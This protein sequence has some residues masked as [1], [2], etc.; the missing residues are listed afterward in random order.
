MAGPRR[1][2]ASSNGCI[3]CMPANTSNARSTGGAH[4]SSPHRRAG[5]E[6]RGGRQLRQW[7]VDA[8]KIALPVFWAPTASPGTSSCVQ[9]DYLHATKSNSASRSVPRRLEPVLSQVRQRGKLV[10]WDTAGGMEQLRFD[11]HLPL[12][13]AS[14]VAPRAPF[15]ARPARPARGD[16]SSMWSG[17][18]LGPTVV[19]PLRR[20]TP[21]RSHPVV[22]CAGRGGGGGGRW[23]AGA[24]IS[25]SD[26]LTLLRKCA[27]RRSDLTEGTCATS[28]VPS[29]RDL[30]L[31][32]LLAGK[33][34]A[35]R[36]PGRRPPVLDDAGRWPAAA[37]KRTGQ[38]GRSDLAWWQARS[39]SRP[40]DRRRGRHRVPPLP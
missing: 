34:L 33:L 17:A 23:R 8:S 12:P 2:C 40:S 39:C 16:R 13:G 37:P 27:D 6:L 35:G 5:L 19:L 36:R 3:Q 22:G 18:D 10:S 31:R 24:G 14:F 9:R 20:V 38:L 26:L 1:S 21:A 15:P 7:R 25:R 28:S 4:H 11:G 29:Q 30:A 32:L